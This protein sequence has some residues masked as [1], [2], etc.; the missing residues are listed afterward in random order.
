MVFEYLEVQGV[1]VSLMMDRH[2]VDMAL[3]FSTLYFFP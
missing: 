3:T 1:Q 2:D